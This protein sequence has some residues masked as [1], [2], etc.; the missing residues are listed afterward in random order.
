MNTAW[1]APRSVR[2]I[3]AWVRTY[4]LGL[5]ASLKEARREEIAADLWEQVQEAAIRDGRSPD[6][7]LLLRWLWGLP[8]DLSWRLGHFHGRKEKG[9]TMIASS[10]TRTLTTA[11]SVVGSLVVLALLVLQVVAQIEYERQVDYGLTPVWQVT[12]L[13]IGPLSLA[14]IVGGFYF[15]RKMPIVGALLVTFG[16]VAVAVMFFWLIVPIVVAIGLSAYAFRRA[17]RIQAGG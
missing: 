17:W 9:D 15:M 10:N 11:V 16:S 5:S 2:F 7:H 3:Q 4:T 8:D 1:A 12:A 13:T 6:A 14:S